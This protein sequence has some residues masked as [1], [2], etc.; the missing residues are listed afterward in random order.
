MHYQ[1]KNQ[2]MILLE[3]ALEPINGTLGNIRELCA[4]LCFFI[5]APAPLALYSWELAR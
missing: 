5:P 3:T 1:K 2:Q 4:Q